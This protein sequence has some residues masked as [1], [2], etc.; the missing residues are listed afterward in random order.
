M[1]ML[2]SRVDKSSKRD[3]GELAP[4]FT[5]R[6]SEDKDTDF[7]SRS[8]IN[9]STC[10]SKQSCGQNHHHG[11]SDIG[12]LQSIK[13]HTCNPERLKGQSAT[14][15]TIFFCRYCKAYHSHRT[16]F[17]DIDRSYPHVPYTLRDLKRE[18]LSSCDFR[19]IATFPD[20]SLWTG[21]GNL[22][23]ANLTLVHIVWS[24]DGRL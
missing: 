13:I 15:S 1:L 4:A 2:K 8:P 18:D 14:D 22:R 9:L 19:S 6:L 17:T 12:Y 7:A 3:A 11:E 24:S 10:L 23:F 20:L 16:L 21:L 5:C